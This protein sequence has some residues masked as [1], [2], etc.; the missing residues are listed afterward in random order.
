MPPA[1]R[2]QTVLFGTVYGAWHTFAPCEKIKFGAWRECD[3]AVSPA[4]PALCVYLAAPTNDNTTLLKY[5]KNIFAR[6]LTKIQPRGCIA[7]KQQ[8]GVPHVKGAF[9]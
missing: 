6:H 8:C 3:K 7:P 4:L 1:V 9:L 5:Q 2:V